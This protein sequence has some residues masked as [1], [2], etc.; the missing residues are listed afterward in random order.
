M[1]FLPQNEIIFFCS[2]YQNRRQK[3]VKEKG[4]KGQFDTLI[5]FF[6]KGEEL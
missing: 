5:F 3:E 1:L 2:L 4:K 6:E